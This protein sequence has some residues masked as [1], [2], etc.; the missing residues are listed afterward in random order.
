MKA[1]SEVTPITFVV[2]FDSMNALL[3]SLLGNDGHPTS[4]S[5]PN[6]QYTLLGL[7]KVPARY[8]SRRI[9]S[10]AI[11][12]A[13]VFGVG[14]IFAIA[15]NGLPL[16][17]SASSPPSPFRGGSRTDTCDTV[18]HG[19][20]CSPKVTRYWGQ[21]SPYF[22]VRSEISPDVPEGCTITF[23]Q[24]L[25]RHGARDPTAFKTE[26]YN[27]TISKLQ[28]NIQT[29]TGQY[30]FLN[31]YE[32]NLGA[33]NLT[34]FGEQQLLN[35][36]F[37]FYHRYPELTRTTHPFVRASGQGR[38]VESAEK[39]C[40]GYRDARMD[41]GEAD[42]GSGPEVNVVIE[43]GEG[44][45]N[46]LSHSL[47]TA[48]EADES[49]H[50]AQQK[51]ASIFVP[52]IQTRLNTDMQGADLSAVEIINLMD[53]CPFETIACNNEAG[54]CNDINRG[55]LAPF[56][57]LFTEA[58]WH[59]YS[60]FQS[61]GKFYGYGPGHPLGPTQG[62]GFVNEL[63]ARLTGIAVRDHTSVN[64]T[65]DGH[66]PYTTF[67][68]GRA[69]YADFSHDN[70][71]VSIF[72]ALGIYNATTPLPNDTIVEATDG[73]A[74]GFSAAWTVPFAGRM[75]VE[76]MT[77][78]DPTD[79]DDGSAGG[80]ELVRILI[81]DRVIA[82]PQ[83]NSDGLGRCSLQAF[84]NSLEFAKVGGRWNECFE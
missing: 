80:E 34:T 81:N 68:R 7:E 74:A 10:I 40:Q 71:M 44:W 28:A 25:S 20:Q 13:V 3:R 48:F 64:M 33:D 22:S 76:K 42:Y 30:A 19:Y 29:F 60:Y 66:W 61:L 70:D 52:P 84:I 56:C 72:S 12:L 39:W 58:E 32:Y 51:W 41:G 11:S 15:S 14:A 2:A 83:C 63:I 6:Y 46:T 75:F 31:D 50:E 4:S 69:L 73:R 62:V 54:N 27:A 37:A 59:Q 49:G 57:A 67:P 21:Y 9:S 35:A 36:G 17:S 18:F 55:H 77:C 26:T 53:L 45:N 24:V 5:N 47:C 8:C 65:L 43:E 82:L 79:D 23:A 1:K 78:E 38:V 16:T